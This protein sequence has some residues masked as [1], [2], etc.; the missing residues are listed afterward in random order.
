MNE[1]FRQEYI[2]L[3][4]P[5][6]DEAPLEVISLRATVIGVSRKI[7]PGW[8]GGEG[9]NA[10]KGTRRVELSAAVRCPVYTHPK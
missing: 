9:R 8:R 1:R 4:G 7:T 3:Y 6:I 10:Q 2:R 5:R